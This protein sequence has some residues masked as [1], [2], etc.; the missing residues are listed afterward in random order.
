MEYNRSFNSCQT[1]W[2]YDGRLNMA[3]M[4]TYASENAWFLLYVCV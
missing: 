2:K 3:G 4:F 1:V